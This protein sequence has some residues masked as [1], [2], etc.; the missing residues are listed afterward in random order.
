MTIEEF[1]AA[2]DGDY[3]EVLSRLSK[4]ALIERLIK[5]YKKDENYNHLRDGIA[6]ADREKV[7]TASH[8]LK[9][10][11]L[12]LGFKKLAETST[13]LC[14]ATRNSYAD[15]AQELYEKVKEAQEQ[16]ISLID[17]LG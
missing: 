14:E 9:G 1:Y 5:L 10:L 16:V 12:N 7:F 13:A 11:A 6:S 15:N 8:T 3:N 2:L 4:A 17:Q